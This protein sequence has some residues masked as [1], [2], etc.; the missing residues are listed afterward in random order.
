MGSEEL[1][2]AGYLLGLHQDVRD[3]L[4]LWHT[5]QLDFDTAC[6]FDIQL[7][8]FAG[9]EPTLAYLKE[10]PEPAAAAAVAYIEAC[11]KGGDFADLADPTYCPIQA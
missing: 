5:K 10:Q 2:F 4:L 1:M 3:S 6:G 7:V 8:V 11:K 9:V